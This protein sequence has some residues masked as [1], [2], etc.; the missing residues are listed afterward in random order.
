[1]HLV[2]CHHSIHIMLVSAA[3]PRMLD[4]PPRSL[5]A[6]PEHYATLRCAIRSASG[7]RMMIAHLLQRDSTRSDTYKCLT[8]IRSKRHQAESAES[9]RQKVQFFWLDDL[10]TGICLTWCCRLCVWLLPLEN[11]VHLLIISFI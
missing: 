3:A 4:Q 6:L 2:S 8:G 5:K 9:K 1:M 10:L 7:K 11:R